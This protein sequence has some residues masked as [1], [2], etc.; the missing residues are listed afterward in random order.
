MESPVL[1]FVLIASCPL[2]GHH[3]KDPGSIFFAPSLQ[4]VA[5]IDE[6]PPEFP[7]LQAEQSHSSQPLLTGEVLQ[8][9]DHL[10]G[11]PLDSF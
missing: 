6:I 3:G 8:S 10:G 5:H 7:F 11:P 1:Q 4:V 9:P 2:T